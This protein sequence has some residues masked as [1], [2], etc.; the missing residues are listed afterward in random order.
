MKQLDD[1]IIHEF[2]VPRDI[3]VAVGLLTDDRI[4]FEKLN[5]NLHQPQVSSS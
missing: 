3:A 5:I 1:Y 4:N 2:A